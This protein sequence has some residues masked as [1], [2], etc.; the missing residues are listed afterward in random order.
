MREQTLEKLYGMK[1]NGMAEV[2]EEQ[3]RQAQSAELSFDERFAMLVD[4]QWIW[5]ENRA[6]AR[7][8]RYAGFKLQASME[9]VNYR[10]SRGLNRRVMEELASGQWILHGRT[11]L[12]TGPTGLGKSFLACALGHQACRDG[13]RVLYAYA[14]KLFREL[15]Q[16]QVDGSLTRY[17]KKLALVELLVVDDFGLERAKPDQHRLF[18]E[19]LDDRHGAT[20]VT[21]QYPVEAWHDLIADPTVADAILDRLV[22]KAYTIALKGESMR[23]GAA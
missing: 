3:R 13:H 17:L 1:L 15:G 21:S 6:L 5:K 19:V 16:A 4:R 8:L 23:K 18:L 7:R 22:H 12:I 20:L 14:P 11:C 9:E 2:Y 10:H